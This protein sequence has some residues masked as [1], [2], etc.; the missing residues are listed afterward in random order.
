MKHL[1]R[2]AFLLLLALPSLPATAAL[3]AWLDRDRMEPGE[4]V[5][6]T[7]QRDG[8]G[9]SQPDLAPLQRDFAILGRASGSTVQIV[10]GRMNAQVQLRLTLAPKHAGLITVPA[11][12]WDGERSPT[13]ALTV[14][15][16]SAG[17]A[18]AAPSSHVFMTS[19]LG[20]K[21]PYVQ[22]ATTLKLRLYSDQP[23]YQASLDLAAS[24]DVLVQQIGRDRQSS[25]MRGGR[26]YQVIE[27]DYLLFPQ[28]SGRISLPGPVLEAQVADARGVDPFFDKAMGNL[29]GGN[30]FAGMMNATRP[31]RLQGDAVVLDARP[32]PAG[33]AGQ[34]WLPAQ[35]V[36]LEESWRPD[37]GR[38]HAGEPLTRHLRLSALGL[39]AAQLPDL[40][41]RMPLPDGIK[42]YPDQPRL[43]TEQQDGNVSGSR[44]QDIALIA[45][46]PGRYPLPAMRLAWWDTTRNSPREVVL[47]ARTLEI[48]PGAAGGDTAAP[49]PPEARPAS[50]SSPPPGPLSVAAP[51]A[52]ASPWP[53]LSLALGLLWLATL[54]AWW[55]ARRPGPSSNSSVAVAAGTD[56]IPAGEAR[57]AF[58]QACRDNAATA[59]RRHVLAWAHAHW[60]HDPPAGLNALA[61]R[62]PDPRLPTLLR[63]LDRACYAGG[64]WRGEPLAEALAAFPGS[65]EKA[66]GKA[67]PLATLYP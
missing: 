63:E 2:L 35:R 61:R 10:N 15:G 32:R 65:A 54:A 27:R 29:F 53:W 47:P 8:R 37:E 50:P 34:D 24:N 26:R 6:L 4:S 30:P 1:Q 5:E 48:L 49:L 60:P 18:A 46:R 3:Q 28:R 58:R 13:L 11:L 57:T 52:T 9:D 51:V 22:G 17:S 40:A 31:L 66:G 67:S 21:Q 12:N 55:R 33:A 7:L 42:A 59:A 64:D 44:E 43:A 36:S 20:Q 23:L 19:T 56:S 62:L 41:A 25:E 39:T 38:V 16:N 45:S 14:A